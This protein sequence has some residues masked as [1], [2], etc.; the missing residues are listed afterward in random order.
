MYTTRAEIF[1]NPAASRATR[2]GVA[3]GIHA[4]VPAAR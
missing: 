4:F 2:P 3:A 1:A